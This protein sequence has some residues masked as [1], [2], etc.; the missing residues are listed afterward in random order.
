MFSIISHEINANQNQKEITM[1]YSSEWP[2]SKKQLITWVSNDVE[3][4]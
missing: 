2:E 4:L 3:K 1:P